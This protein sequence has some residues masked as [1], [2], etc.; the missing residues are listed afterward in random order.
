MD[1]LMYLIDSSDS[2]TSRSLSSHVARLYAHCS[3][4]KVTEVLRSGIPKSQ[5]FY[6]DL[7]QLHPRL[8]RQ[9]AI[10]AVEVDRKVRRH[11]LNNFAKVLLGSNEAYAPIHAT[12][13][14]SNIPPGLRFGEDLLSQIRMK[15]P[16]LLDDKDLIRQWTEDVLSL[17]IRS[18]VPFGTILHLISTCLEMCRAADT[19]SW[20]LPSLPGLVIRCW[21][22]AK[23]GVYKEPFYS[24]CRKVQLSSP[25]QPKAIDQTALEDCLI[26][27]V[28]QTR[29]ERVSA[30]PRQANLSLLLNGMLLDVHI[31][32]RLEFLQ[33]FCKHSP[34]LNFDLEAWPPSEEER[35]LIPIWEH[36]VLGVLPVSSSMALF[37]RSLHIHQ[38]DKFLP[39]DLL[40]Q[41]SWALTWE[42]QCSLWARWESSIPE[43]SN[44][45]PVTRKGKEK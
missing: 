20:I 10:S 31:D 23:F 36:C 45:F 32:G 38:H 44:D 25:S 18:N 39:D 17:A 24:F 29:D 40:K 5:T 33:L 35:K 42:Q 11:I 26:Q 21:S 34:T 14:H 22:T 43:A 30:Q 6:Q 37:R 7:G 28:L 16:K 8:L 4:K 2:W 41:N 9:I 13:I 1:E 15:E 3:P 12:E 27:H 19:K